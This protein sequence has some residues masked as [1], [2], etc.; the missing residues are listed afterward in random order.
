[1]VYIYA[2][3]LFIICL[4][5]TIFTQYVVDSEIKVSIYTIIVIVIFNVVICSIYYSI[6]NANYKKY[7]NNK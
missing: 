4:L 2:L 5:C 6:R 7:I 1:M 3:V